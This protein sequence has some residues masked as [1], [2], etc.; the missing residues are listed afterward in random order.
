MI[1]RSGLKGSQGMARIRAVDM[2]VKLIKKVD[3]AHAL[4]LEQATAGLEPD[5]QIDCATQALLEITP[6]K[7][8]F[9]E[10][11]AA[12][13]ELNRAMQQFKG[14]LGMDLT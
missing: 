9:G 10:L 13:E 14:T 1:G 12:T 4:R 11:K 7:A 3:A 8:L 2:I 6:P 5:E